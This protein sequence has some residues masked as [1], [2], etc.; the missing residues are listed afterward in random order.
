MNKFPIIIILVLVIFLIILSISKD[1]PERKA[2]N[3]EKRAIFVS[4]IEL[5]KYIKNNEIST[6]KE[7]IKKMINNIKNLGFNTIILQVRA[8]SD[9]IYESDIFPWSSCVSNEEGITPGYDI[10]NYFIKIS[11]EKNINLYAWINPYRV[12]TSNNV[13][14][15]TESNPAY[16]YINTDVLYVNNG[17]YYNPAKEETIQLI[18]SGVSEI[19]NNY[20]VDGICFDD[21]FYPDKIVGEKEYIE[22]K[23]NNIEITFDEYR[24]QT[25]ND[26]VERV[27]KECQKKKI[28]FGIS[29]SGNIENNYDGIYADVKKWGSSN[30]YVDYLM[31]Q[32]YYGFFNETQAFHNVVKKWDKL[33]TNKNIKLI[34]ALAFYKVGLVDEYAKSGANEWVENNNIIMRE[35]IMSRNLKN[36]DGFALYR[37]DYLYNEE[38]KTKTTMKEIENIK[39]IMNKSLKK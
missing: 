23:K 36:Y 12:R 2:Q 6:S 19:I 30:K 25:V 38:L 22:Y 20:D 11:H 1:E 3:N 33:V 8:F 9:S 24:L 28:P 29:P 32:I 14:S 31:P 5:G 21:Y 16:K 39:K 10:L 27:H 7:N 13:E 4:Y 37:Y 35:I 34:P 17:I 26:M 15:I 18:V